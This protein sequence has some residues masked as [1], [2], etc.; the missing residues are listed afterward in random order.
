MS[1]AMTTRMTSGPGSTRG[2]AAARPPDCVARTSTSSTPR[3]GSSELVDPI[4][5]A[6]TTQSRPLEVHDHAPTSPAAGTRRV[7]WGHW[8]LDRG[9]QG[10]RRL[11][12]GHRPL[13]RP[14]DRR[15]FGNFS[16]HDSLLQ[17]G[18]ARRANRPQLPAPRP[19][20][21][22]FHPEEESQVWAL[23]GYETA[24]RGTRYLIEFADTESYVCVFFAAFDRAIQPGTH[25]TRT[26]RPHPARL[27]HP[28][29]LSRCR[30]SLGKRKHPAP[31]RT[32]NSRRWCRT[33]VSAAT[34]ASSPPSRTGLALALLV[35]CRRIGRP[36]RGRAGHAAGSSAADCETR[37]VRGTPWTRYGHDLVTC[38]R[39]IAWTPA[40]T[41]VLE[42]W[43]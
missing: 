11:R 5:G 20:M 37:P 41:Q 30:R 7:A 39:S 31:S 16:R 35:T 33:R 8:N 43:Y 6:R 3:S 36:V 25:P 4:D 29:S 38:A 24:H 17:G 9:Q 21:S 42:Y 22:D 34:L 26:P 27:V 32:A 2:T 1:I 18:H 10:G 12:G 40:L 23:E 13:P 15:E 28:R 14:E 19:P